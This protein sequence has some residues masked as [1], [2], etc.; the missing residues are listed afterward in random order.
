MAYLFP[1]SGKSLLAHFL[2]TTCVV[3]LCALSD[4]AFAQDKIRVETQYDARGQVLRQS[5]PYYPGETVRWMEYSH[6]GLDRQI[7]LTHP[8]SKTSA[9]RYF[10]GDFYSAV[11]IT[12]EN[13]NKRVTHFDAFGN[14]VHRDRFDDGVQ[15][16][17][18][19]E[20]DA[21]NRLTGI[22]DAL[23]S[24]WTYL[25][26]GHGNRVRAQDPDLGCRQMTY[27]AANRLIEQRAA[28]GALITY[29]YDELDRVVSKVVDKD[30]LQY[31]DC[32]SNS[33][34]SNRLP[35]AVD[36]A[37]GPITPGMST[38]IRILVNDRDA[39][40]NN[41]TVT[42]LNGTPV[43]PGSQLAV[44]GG[45]VTLNLDKSLTFQSE[46]GNLGAHSFTYTISDGYG[47]SVANVTVHVRHPNVAPVVANAIADQQAT[48]E[49][50]WTF[51]IA[52][53]TFDDADGDPLVIS[54]TSGDGS[55]LP[56]WLDFD[57]VSRSFSGL[58]PLGSNGTW[59]IN[60]LASDGTALVGEPFDL[61]VSEDLSSPLMLIGS[62]GNDDFSYDLGD[63]DLKI[64]EGSGM[65]SVDRIL[66][67]NGVSSNN[68]SVF[69][70]NATSNS[71]ILQFE[72]GGRV[73][74][75]DQF[76]AGEGRGV[77][78][79]VFDNNETWLADDIAE[80][81]L[82]QFSTTGND[83]IVAFED[84]SGSV[85]GL[86]GSDTIR[87]GLGADRIWGRGGADVI[88]GRDGKDDLRGNGSADTIDG[89]GDDDKL[90][91]GGGKD[92]LI[93]GP[94]SDKF[95]GG[96]GN[97][98][99]VFY[100][101][102]TGHDIIED[103]SAGAGNSDILKFESTVFADHSAVLAAA[104]DNGTDTTITVGPATSILLKNVLVSDLHQDDFA[105]D[106][107][108][109]PGNSAPINFNDV[110]DQSGTEDTYW[111]FAV[112]GDAFYD[113]DGDELSFAAELLSGTA[114][115]IW[116]SFDALNGAFSGTPPQDYFGVL[117]IRVIASDGQAVAND[118]FNLTIAS[119]NDGPVVANSIPDQSALEETAWSFSVPA[120]TFFDVDGDTLTLGASL[121]DGSVLPV[122]L[123][124]DTGTGT[125][126]GTPPIGARGTLSL[127]VSAQ[128]TVQT[129]Y[130]TFDVEIGA[131]NA[132]P[133]VANAIG[134]QSVLEDTPWS[135]IVPEN[136]FYDADGDTLS[137]SA[138]LSGGAALPSWLDLSVD[139]RTFFGTPPLNYNGLI[140]IEVS[141]SDGQL[142][143]SDEFVLSIDA[144]NDNPVLANAISDQAA[145]EGS[146]F[147]FSFPINTFFDADGD[148][149]VYTA[150]L[151]DGSS[152][153]TWL[154]FNE[155]SRLFTGT[156][157]PASNG[158]LAIK[159]NASDGVEAA[160]STFD[161]V[162]FEGEFPPE[163]VNN[164]P[165]QSV[166]SGAFWDFSFAENTFI[167]PDGDPIVY[168]AFELVEGDYSF[169]CFC[170]PTFVQNLPAWLSF[171]S[172]NRRFS[173][174]PSPSDVS[175]RTFVV[176]A[177][178]ATEPLPQND[179]AVGN[180]LKA[181]RADQFDLTIVP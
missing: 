170:T 116:L 4:A 41:L 158:T 165:D 10:P 83:H 6:D 136:T 67:G 128:D 9:T 146:S 25:Y 57:P 1:G 92:T 12:D 135:Y 31:P 156:P 181:R 151:A 79:V 172:A 70:A 34:P 129:T 75:V 30:A 113:P 76:A 164:I 40:G 96:N 43:Q 29:A 133:I 73:E 27:D 13:G 15:M 142:S 28:D 11:E 55:A 84:S 144:V 47:D 154:N 147:F 21:L 102:E 114:L 161:L 16:R 36:D 69:R 49:T 115:P 62:S 37:A 180:A 169:D 22:T 52:A 104:S 82:A 38:T 101:A 126:S 162:I 108:G 171:D 51:A 78:Q 120:N 2:T 72:D 112:P 23:G 26:D 134:N 74:F 94:G 117:G 90:R 152:L 176:Y 107:V 63:R 175:P 87:G 166:A 95:W 106:T 155:S 140:S 132:R 50:A 61:I 179:I 105:F 85:D 130:A 20:Y 137:Y 58:P 14:E 71:I 68:V 66:L 60:V 35:S 45:L 46:V 98:T 163:R 8:D 24:E 174:T 103:F 118:T 131:T 145:T 18:T 159:V 111:Q 109:Q 42:A 173:G 59:P 48:E 168:T 127:R 77:E 32:S 86:N 148:A 110:L 54:A 89:G 91:G 160:E 64:V 99:F 153:P 19:Y 33:P 125:F 149:L 44:T 178:E 53:D 17:T 39:D 177:G 56:S 97:D 5:L 157:P 3:T 150:M 124:F 121:A 122:W 93:G 139:N 100:A 138:A 143:V 88:Y 123:A 7:L 65:G 80:Q 119:V 141:A 167:D 81:V